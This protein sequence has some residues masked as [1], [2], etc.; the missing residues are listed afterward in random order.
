LPILHTNDISA[1]VAR[2]THDTN[3]IKSGEYE[4]ARHVSLKGLPRAIEQPPLV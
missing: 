2:T 4:G 3:I 1:H